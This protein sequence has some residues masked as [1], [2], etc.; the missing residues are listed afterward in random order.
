MNHRYYF[1]HRRI[2][3]HNGKTGRVTVCLD[4][5][6]QIAAASWCSPFDNFNKKLG[7]TIAQGR[8]VAF[9]K[10]PNRFKDRGGASKPVQYSTTTDQDKLRD[11]FNAALSSLMWP[12]WAKG[13]PLEDTLYPT[14]TK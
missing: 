8:V 4:T 10:T 2:E 12:R 3:S 14:P 7:R 9:Q 5:E 6:K 1:T 11:Q 13:F